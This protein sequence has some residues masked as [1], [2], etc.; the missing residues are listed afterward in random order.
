MRDV[1]VR[2]GPI[3]IW[4]L[5]CGRKLFVEVVVAR[6]GGLREHEQHNRQQ[7]RHFQH[8]VDIL[9][10]S[11]SNI[12]L[13]ISSDGSGLLYSFRVGLFGFFFESCWRLS[14]DPTVAIRS[15]LWWWITHFTPFISHHFPALALGIKRWTSPVNWPSPFLCISYVYA[16]RRDFPFF[17]LP[18]APRNFRTF[19]LLFCLIQYTRRTMSS[20]TGY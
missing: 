19:F 8:V 7:Q 15:S 10:Y 20:A 9:A 11:S 6:A 2:I 3:I 1:S 14:G 4:T 16:R 5:S 13:R 12:Q 18:A 17:F